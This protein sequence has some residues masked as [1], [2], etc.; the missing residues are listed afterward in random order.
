MSR[1]RRAQRI[2]MLS[3]LAFALAFGAYADPARQMTLSPEA[4][5]TAEASPATEGLVQAQ[6]AMIHA[7][8]SGYSGNVDL[9]FVRQMVPQKRAAIAMAEVVRDYGADPEVRHAAKG[10]MDDD[11]AEL[12]WL[13]DWLEKHGQP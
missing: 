13:V 7:L 2:A 5:A 6:Q 12:D 1:F 9:D 11:Q 10:I 4:V 8:P 3:P